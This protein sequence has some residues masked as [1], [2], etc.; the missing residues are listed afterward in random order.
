MPVHFFPKTPFSMN[1]GDV[2]TLDEVE[3]ICLVPCTVI[4]STLEGNQPVLG[5]PLMPH[6]NSVELAIK[7]Q[8]PNVKPGQ[9]LTEARSL[10]EYTQVGPN[11]VEDIEGKKIL[12]WNYDSFDGFIM[13]FEDNTYLKIEVT[14]GCDGPEV[15]MEE[16]TLNDLMRMDLLPPGV[17]DEHR[18]EKARLREAQDTVQGAHLLACAIDNL[19]IE[20][21]KEMVAKT[22]PEI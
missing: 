15:S 10:G 17:W 16:L 4:G 5:S 14:S 7:S 11:D 2:V 18:A 21:V 8:N 1:V 13:V 20:R 12:K 19:G 6:L 22:A 9:S 3:W